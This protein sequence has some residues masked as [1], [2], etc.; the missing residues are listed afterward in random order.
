MF[1][2]VLLW[3]SENSSMTLGMSFTFFCFTL[4][5]QRFSETLGTLQLWKSVSSRVDIAVFSQILMS[6]LESDHHGIHTVVH[7]RWYLLPAWFPWGFHWQTDIYALFG[8]QPLEIIHFL[9]WIICVTQ[10][11]C[12]PWSLPSLWWNCPITAA[13]HPYF[14]PR[15]S[16]WH[17]TFLLLGIV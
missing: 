8:S 9:Q 17:R 11:C 16:P 5:K 14:S 1:A 7:R 6:K 13:S 4:V 15:L 10:A 12:F 3:L 2:D